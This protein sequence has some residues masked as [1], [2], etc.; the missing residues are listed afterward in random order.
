MTESNPESHPS[1]LERPD[2]NNAT[3]IHYQLIDES[4]EWK[5]DFY[6]LNKQ[7][8]YKKAD[9]YNSGDRNV[10]WFNRSYFR[11]KE[12][13]RIVET[14]ADQLELTSEQ[15]KRAASWF[16]SF[17]LSSWGPPKEVVAYSVCAYLVHSD[18]R[19]IR[20]CHPRTPSER[21]DTLFRQM[22]EALQLHESPTLGKNVLDSTYGKVQNRI[23]GKPTP[24]LE[25]I[26]KYSR[27]EGISGPFIPDVERS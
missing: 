16:M 21:K 13:M 27:F 6:P 4:A 20:H 10:N 12:K 1:P 26:D 3:F 14:L 7:E 9:D 19:D 5:A 18:Q 24:Y 23:E 15:R 8:W 2:T 25:P 17:D 11:K 22:E